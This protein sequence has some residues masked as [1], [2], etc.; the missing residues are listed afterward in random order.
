MRSVLFSLAAAAAV[1]ATPALA[2]E[3]RVEAR[4]GINWVKGVPGSVS[5]AGVAAGHDMDLGSA[6][7]GVELSADKLL[8]KDAKVVFGGAVRVGTNVTEA[9]KVYAI[10]GYETTFENNSD[11]WSVGAGYQHSFGRVYLKA[12]YRRH[13]DT[14]VNTVLTGVGFK[15]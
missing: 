7:A 8:I 2:G 3:S 6:F 9:G 13:I 15:F 11:D 1:V 10:G 14:D 12:E 4:T 5:S